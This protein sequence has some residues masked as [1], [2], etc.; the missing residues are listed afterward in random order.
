M[1]GRIPQVLRRYLSTI[2][3]Q[4]I[5]IKPQAAAS[6]QLRAAAIAGR[7]PLDGRRQSS[8]LA[9]K[10]LQTAGAVL[11]KSHALLLKRCAL[12]RPCDVFKFFFA[13]LVQGFSVFSSTLFNLLRVNISRT[14]GALS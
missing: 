3:G 5:D 6:R 4:S 7:V 2:T 8:A 1:L 9:S 12:Q 13:F 10:Y 11:L 14:I